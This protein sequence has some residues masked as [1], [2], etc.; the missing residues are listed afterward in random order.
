MNATAL[1]A[2][3]QACHDD[4]PARAAGLLERIEPAALDAARWPLLGFL[5]VH[6]F[7]EAL[8]DWGRAHRDLQAWLASAVEPPAVLWRHAAVAATLAGEPDAA[9]SATARLATAA[10]AQAGQAAELVA[11]AATA[12][13]L[14]G[15]PAAEAGAHVLAAIAPLDGSAWQSASGLDIAAAAQ[16]NNIGSHLVDRP[17]P[18]LA[19]PVLR[20][21][22]AAS[23]LQ[24]ERLWQRAGTW[25]NHERALYLR[26]LAASALG[27]AA[28]ALVHAQQ[29]LALLEA[30]D[31]G[32][33]E[34]VDRAFLQLEAAFALQRLGRGTE[35]AARRAQADEIAA[36][37]GA[38]GL[39][40][41][42]ADRVAR[43]AALAAGQ[44]G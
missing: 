24:A 32:G 25:V 1:L 27:D 41:W 14:T 7:G 20:D 6:V 38:P 10:G 26:A 12:F 37:F 43:N 2:E 8:G 19:V 44:P 11:L 29:A 18:D 17:L 13:G 3:A 33:A 22:L 9:A 35:A 23:V 28:A 42:F 21:A 16:C 30:N 31:P 5:L 36:S 39:T 15:W 34:S 4:D 40:Q